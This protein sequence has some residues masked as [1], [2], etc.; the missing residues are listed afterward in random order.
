ML[1]LCTSCISEDNEESKSSRKHKIVSCADASAPEEYDR[2]SLEVLSPVVLQESLYQTDDLFRLIVDCA[3]VEW[4][5][6]SL[7]PK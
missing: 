6:A 5:G 1:L 7:G 3:E 4:C 2:P